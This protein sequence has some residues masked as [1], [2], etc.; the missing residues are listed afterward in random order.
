[1]K[2]IATLLTTLFVI[3]M[4]SLTQS[5]PG[6][7]SG[8]GCSGG[9]CHT[10]Q[11]GNITA[12][13]LTG[14]QVQITVS[15]TTS[16]VGGELVNSSG[17][18][19]AVINSTGSNPFTLTAPSAGTYTV[20]AGYKNPS[21]QWGT[22]SVNIVAAP[23]APSS[24][25][26]SPI[27]NTQINISWSDNSTN[28]DGFKIER[29][30]TTGGTYAE[31]AQVGS[32]VTSYNSTSL[33]GGTQYCYRVR[34]YNGAGNSAYSNESCNTTFPDLPS[35]PLNLVA[36]L[37]QNP[38]S[39][40]LIWTDNSNNEEGFII[41][42]ETATEAFVIIDSV[43]ANVSSYIDLSVTNLTYN[44]RVSAYNIT[45]SS[46]YSNVAQIA[47]PVELT[48][49]TANVVLGKVNLNWQTATEINNS[50][51]NVERNN[52]TSTEW[53]SIGFVNGNGTTTA[54]KSYSFNDENIAPGKYLYR[55]KQIDFNGIF[56]YSNIIEVVV[57]VPDKFS[58]NQNYPNPFNPST[59][60]E[61][62]L[63][64]ES[65]VTLKVYNILGKEVASLVNEQKPAGVH[66]INFD[67]S[68]L[69]SGLYIY[70]IST[71]SLEQ[72]R[73]MLLLK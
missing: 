71:G 62:Q 37:I 42:K 57:N 7:N 66:K 10:L 21:R 41:E 52:T 16:N 20:N 9:G 68:G 61:F 60:I 35:V 43:T 28:E 40:E 49:F 38:L 54:P 48:S 70:K 33:A 30:T 12:T 24:L 15:G 55:L 65:F 32:N 69:T 64:K 34:S 39:V 27:S 13:V 50:G 8:P 44:Y 19:V 45:G 53:I 72:T 2:V 5:E 31:I 73:K 23:P 17:T 47:V 11:S 26:S 1:M 63:P 25:N 6:F 29:K 51:F 67:A 4:V 14:N 3:I 18:V 46:A 56:E 22:T 36:N 58:L 59:T